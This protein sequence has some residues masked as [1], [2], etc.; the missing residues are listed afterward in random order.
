[1]VFMSK[2]RHHV[3]NYIIRKLKKLEWI[4]KEL[5]WIFYD[6]NKFLQ[7]FFILKII[8]KMNFICLW[9]AHTNTEKCRG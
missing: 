3:I 9:S 8:S 1:M 5:E 6:L 4:K 7:L 2:Q